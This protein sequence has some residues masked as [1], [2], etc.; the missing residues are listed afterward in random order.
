MHVAPEAQVCSQLPPL[1]ENAQVA[2]PAQV[3][4][5][6]PAPATAPSAAPGAGVAKAKLLIHDD[7][8]SLAD[9]MKIAE[10]NGGDLELKMFAAMAQTDCAACGYDCEGYAHALATG[11]TNDVSLCIS[12]DL[13]TTDTLA[14]LMKDAGKPVEG[15]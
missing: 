11:E 6:A 3:I 14:K 15:I 1:H 7:K 10:D 8:L 12:G 2:P 13:D 5:Q 9:R 4:A